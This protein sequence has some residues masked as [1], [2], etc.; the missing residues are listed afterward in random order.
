MLQSYSGPGLEENAKQ[1]GGGWAG[2]LLSRG[3]VPASSPALTC[4]ISVE[5]DGAD[6]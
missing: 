1:G 2:A 6:C 4:T 5:G 3:K